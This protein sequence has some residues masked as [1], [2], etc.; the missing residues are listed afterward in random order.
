MRINYYNYVNTQGCYCFLYI[1]LFLVKL[2]TVLFQFGW[3]FCLLSTLIHFKL[4]INC[5]KQWFLKY[6]LWTPFRDP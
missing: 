1:F 5:L 4:S 2:V 6:A 3:F